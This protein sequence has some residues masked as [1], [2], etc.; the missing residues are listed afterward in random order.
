MPTQQ[1]A[2]T[3]AV[4]RTTDYTLIVV[5]DN[6]GTASGDLYIDDGVSLVQKEY[7]HLHVVV[8]SVVVPV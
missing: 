4:A 3:T 7:V 1:E 5:L 8:P 6:K 2:N